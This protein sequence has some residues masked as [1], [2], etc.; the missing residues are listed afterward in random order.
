MSTETTT[1]GVK[2]IMIVKI[3]IVRKKKKKYT[4]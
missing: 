2:E 4:F 3:Q 1:N